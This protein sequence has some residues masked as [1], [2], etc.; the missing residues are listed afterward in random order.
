MK[1]AKQI[2]YL[3]KKLGGEGAESDTEEQV[4]K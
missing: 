1:T 4:K 2:A 3:K